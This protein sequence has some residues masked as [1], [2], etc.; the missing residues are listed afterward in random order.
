MR[1]MLRDSAQMTMQDMNGIERKESPLRRT[2]T[3]ERNGHTNGSFFPMVKNIGFHVRQWHEGRSQ[4]I[5]AP[6]TD[7][8]VIRKEVHPSLRSIVG[9]VNLT[10][11]Q[12]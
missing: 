11:F 10:S 2:I 4:V 6:K 7:N 3:K 12:S 9:R 5:T 8:E 1:F